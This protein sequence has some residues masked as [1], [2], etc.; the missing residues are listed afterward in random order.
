MIAIEHEFINC[1][2]KGGMRDGARCTDCGGRGIL[3]RVRPG[4]PDEPPE[5]AA[6]KLDRLKLADLQAIA[7]GLG[8]D[9]SGTRAN[10]I[11]RI[12]AVPS[13]SNETA[14]EEAA[15]EAGTD[16]ESA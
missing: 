6:V 11:E 8:L 16:E 1:T 9:T 14:T 5:E 12:R 4:I 7:E 2:C 15:T 13:E 10:L 3:R